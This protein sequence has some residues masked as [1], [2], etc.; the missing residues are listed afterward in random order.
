MRLVSDR[1][2]GNLCVKRERQCTNPVPHERMTHITF[3]FQESVVKAVGMKRMLAAA[4]TLA[5]GAKARK[6]AAARRAEVKARLN[7]GHG[8]T[9][10]AQALSITE[11]RVRQIRAEIQSGQAG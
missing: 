7:A 11:A 1:P 10:I 5:R 4:E 6:L 8:A 2:F 9:T 3:E